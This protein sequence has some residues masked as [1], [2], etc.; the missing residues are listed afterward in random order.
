MA[1]GWMIGWA[2]QMPGRE[3][4]P[5]SPSG[6][7]VI[8]PSA[9]PGHPPFLNRYRSWRSPVRLDRPPAGCLDPSA[10]RHLD[11]AQVFDVGAVV[12]LAGV[13]GR[14]VADDEPDR[15]AVLD[16]E[17]VRARPCRR[18]RPGPGSSP[19]GSRRGSRRGRRGG[20]GARR[21]GRNPR[22]I[23]ERPHRASPRPPS[24]PPGTARRP[25]DPVGL[26]RHRLRGP[27][28]SGRSG[29][30]RP[31]RGGSRISRIRH[32]SLRTSD[33]REAGKSR[34]SATAPCG[35]STSW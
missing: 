10:G 2:D 21:R 16:P 34:F 35:H 18:P 15:P 28:K 33:H 11:P 3:S 19:G 22:P 14:G 13:A 27:R 31:P 20:S 6:P 29:S 1:D 32:V 17:R 30:R 7:F 24:D 26:A 5:G 8:G 4:S 9:Q 23:Q 25:N 12:Q